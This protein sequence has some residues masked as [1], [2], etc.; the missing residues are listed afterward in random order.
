MVC[1]SQNSWHNRFGK[2]QAMETE[3]PTAAQL[4]E[5]TGTKASTWSLLGKHRPGTGLIQTWA[6]PGL[7]KV[8][9]AGVAG[10]AAGRYGHG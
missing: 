2:D 1:S 7:E 5:L 3:Y 9:R 6:P 10:R 4:E 8:E